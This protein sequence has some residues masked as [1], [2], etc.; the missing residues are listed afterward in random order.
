[1]RFLHT[2][3][4]QIGMKADS[5]GEAGD[6]VREARLEAGEKVIET[7]AEHNVDCVIAAGDLFEHNAV[8]RRLIQ[9][10]ADILSSFKGEVFIIPGNHDP[11]EP[12]SVWHHPAWKYAENLVLCI[13]NKP[14]E[15]DGFTLYPCPLREKYSSRNPTEWIQEAE[16]RGISVGIAH[17]TVEGVQQD[18]LDYPIPRDVAERVG[19]D[20]LALGHWHS[21]ACYEAGDNAVRMAY[22]GTHE[23]SKFGERDSGNVL[24]VELD[25]PGAA[26]EIE[27]VRTGQLSWISETETLVDRGDLERIRSS[28]QEMEQPD[29]TLLRM[30]LTGTLRAEEYP[31]LEHLQDLVQTRFLYGS[32]DGTALRLYPDDDKWIR[33]LPHGVVRE[34][35]LD[36]MEKASASSG[37]AEEQQTAA[38]ALIELYAVLGEVKS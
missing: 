9:R 35:A 11:Y 3:D 23:A 14:I 13:E 24:I 36:L 16:K 20:Y 2:A 10:T 21:T 32:L 22:S 18:E 25:K 38:R 27:R 30:S 28:V 12:G 5:V 29:R 6:R 8:D 33:S 19:V 34:A 17:G 4:W 26:P 1:M 7:A 15:R 37:S 31:E